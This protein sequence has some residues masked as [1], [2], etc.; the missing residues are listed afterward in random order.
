VNRAL[1]RPLLH[2]ST[3]LLL[4]ALLH[5]WHLFRL[6]LVAGGLAAAI[7][8]AARL[9]FPSVAAWAEHL[10]PVFR[11]HEARRPSG[12]GWLFVGYALVAWLPPPAPAVAV[13]SGSLADPAAAVIGRR[14]GGGSRK[15]WAGTAAAMTVTTASAWLWG[16]PLGN[17]FL[18][19]VVGSA[20]ERW[21]G[22]FDDNLVLAPGVGLTVWWL[23]QGLGWG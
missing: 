13:L 9:R 10:V 22:C 21:P 19:G 12:A 17:A 15:S 16:L 11:P 18:A 1:V 7:F 14:F 23:V 3:G 2:A 6:V 8:E 5:S 20:V 4:L